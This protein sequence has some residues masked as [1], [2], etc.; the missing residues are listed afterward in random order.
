MTTNINLKEKNDDKKKAWSGFQ[1]KAHHCHAVTDTEGTF[2]NDLKNVIILETGLTIGGSFMNKNLLSNIK[3][4]SSPLE[5]VTNAGA[6][7][8]FQVGVVNGFG[9]ACYDPD[10]VANI[11]GFAKLE[12]QCRFTYDSCIENAFNVHTNDGQV[13]AQ[14]RWVVC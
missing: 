14:Q 3:T 4:T 2:Q 1:Q 9:E 8:L 10:Q 7:N 11:F 6:K 5:M 12:D 13:Q